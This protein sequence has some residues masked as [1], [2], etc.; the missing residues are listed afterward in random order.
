MAARRV[1]RGRRN[2]LGGIGLHPDGPALRPRA[3]EPISA[4]GTRTGRW[5]H[6][7]VVYVISESGLGDDGVEGLFRERAGHYREMVG[8]LR[9][10]YVHEGASGRFGGVYV[11][12]AA[13]SRDVLFESDVH[14]SRR[15]A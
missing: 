10:F 11:F 14:G 3:R 5:I 2:P 6:V 8:L 7:E 15:D 4:P 12:D 1:S 9:T 13:A